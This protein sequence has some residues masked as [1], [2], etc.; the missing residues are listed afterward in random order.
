MK[1]PDHNND[2]PTST[3]PPDTAFLQ[4]LQHHRSGHLLSDLSQAVREAVEASQLLGKPAGLTLK[5]AIKPAGNGSGAVVV[6]DKLTVKLPEELPQSSFFYTDEAG[7]LHRN[8]PN[9]KELPLR[10][11]ETAPVTELRQPTPSAAAR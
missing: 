4:L 7:N 8:D 3:P 9:Q 6:A 2:T 5:I 1:T 11:V 10:V